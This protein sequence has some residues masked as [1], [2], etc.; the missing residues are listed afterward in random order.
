LKSPNA[1]RLLNLGPTAWTR[2][3]SVYRATAQL[4]PVEN[5]EAVIFAQSL[6]PYL[7][8]GVDQTASEIFDLAACER[9]HLPVVQRLLPGGA[10][11]C[12]VN[13]MLFQWVLPTVETLHPSP[14]RYGDLRA[15]SLQIA[16]AVLAA[17]GEF[18]ITAEF[19]S[20]Q[21]KVRGER[22]GTLAGGQHESATLFLGCLYLSSYDLDSLNRT[23]R[24]PIRES[25]TSIWAEA[26]RP[27]A[28]EMI[29]DTLLTH[30]AR[31][32]KRPIERDTP[33]VEET[34]AAKKIEQT[35]LGVLE[36]E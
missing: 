5:R 12:D 36:A 24:E 3:Q 11:Y 19:D 30:F 1:I 26:P 29:Q 18:G 15:T 27:L 35:M 28:P 8:H 14:L 9:L 10:K 31:E 34:R 32:L 4:L 7:S 23:L 21:F 13:Q 33:R 25:T 22:I 17:L 2:T 20:T 16:N 6:Q